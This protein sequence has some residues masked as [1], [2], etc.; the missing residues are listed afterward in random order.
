[1]VGGSM[2]RLLQTLFLGRWFSM[3]GKKKMGMLAAKQN[4]REDLVYLQ[5]LFE[6]GKVRPVIDRHFPL[7]EVP[8]A[9]RRLGEGNALG[10]VVITM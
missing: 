9:L 7:S 8:E 4:K 5:E 6:S 3:I 10:K 1:M 2:V